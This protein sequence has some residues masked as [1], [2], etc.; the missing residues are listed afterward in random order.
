MVD[1]RYPSGG[2]TSVRTCSC[3]CSSELDVWYL[4]TLILSCLKLDASWLMLNVW[5]SM[6][7][8]CT[9]ARHIHEGLV[10]QRGEADGRIR[11]EEATRVRLALWMCLEGFRESSFKRQVSMYQ[12]TKVW[13]PWN[14]IFASGAPA[15]QPMQGNSIQRDYVAQGSQPWV[16][17]AFQPL[18]PLIWRNS[19]WFAI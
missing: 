19:C 7:G 16:L 15:H 4:G 6:L 10:P 1:A 14:T 3:K 11:F 12:G 9:A 13:K 17:W 18:A 2:A 8:A 5:S